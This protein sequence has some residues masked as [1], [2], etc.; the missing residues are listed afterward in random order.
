MDASAPL[1]EQ[2]KKHFDHVSIERNFRIYLHKLSDI[3]AN[4]RTGKSGFMCVCV[5]VRMRLCV[6]AIY[7]IAEIS[8]SIMWFIFNI[9]EKKNSMPSSIAS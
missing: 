9:E 8:E 3:G 2:H 7:A 5:R 6:C 1:S 4:L